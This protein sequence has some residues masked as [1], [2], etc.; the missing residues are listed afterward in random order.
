MR[1]AG[2]V[3]I[4]LVCGLAVGCASPPKPHVSK[5]PGVVVPGVVS[6]GSAGAGASSGAQGYGGSGGPGSSGRAGS[7]GV[8]LLG[9]WA[10]GG[11][12]N[13]VAAGARAYFRW[14]N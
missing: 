5:P 10:P 2:L 9:G 4:T 8:V 7:R 11:A 13:A 14:L 3:V 6:G 12:H 1:A